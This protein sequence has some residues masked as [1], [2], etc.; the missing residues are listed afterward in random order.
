VC[1]R[2][3]TPQ[4]RRAQVREAQRTYQKRKDTATA[5]EKRRADDLLQLLSDLSSDVESLLQAASTAGNMNRDDDVSKNIQRLWS[6]YDS[7]INNECIKPELRLH[8]IKNH[9]RLESHKVDSSLR[10]DD[11]SNVAQVD[12]NAGVVPSRNAPFDPSAMSFQLV[13]FEETTVMSSYQRTPITDQYMAGRSIY[14]IV[15]E[16]QTAMKDAERRRAEQTNQ[17]Q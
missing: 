6:T 16:R 9:H 4:K 17:D 15:Q 13:R 5:A 12:T 11:V 1:L 8:Q 3:H 7:V 2:S 10:N 14:D